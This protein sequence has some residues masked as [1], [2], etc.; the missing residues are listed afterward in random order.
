MCGDDDEEV[1]FRDLVKDSGEAKSGT[2]GYRKIQ[3]CRERAS[4]DNLQYFWVDTC[5][6]IQTLLPVTMHYEKGGICR[7]KRRELVHRFS[8][9]KK[10]YFLTQLPLLSKN[11]YSTL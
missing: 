5:C 4:R 10:H 11:S 7:R 6:T 8:I 2:T 3:F 9:Q 1:K